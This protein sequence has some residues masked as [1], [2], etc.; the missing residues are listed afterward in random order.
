MHQEVIVIDGYCNLCNKFCQ[1][2]IKSDI[3]NLDLKKIIAR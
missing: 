3:N 1:L 2:I